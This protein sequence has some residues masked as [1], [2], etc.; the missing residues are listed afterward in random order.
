MAVKVIDTLKPKN[1]GTFPVVEAADVAIAANTRLP[2]ALA[3]KASTSDLSAATEDLQQQIDVESARIDEIIALPDGSTTAD[4]ELV[5]IR[6]GSDGTSY[7]SAGDAVRGQIGALK[8]DLTDVKTDF[9]DVFASK[10]YSVLGESAFTIDDVY[11]NNSGKFSEN[12]NFH[13]SDFISV[14][15]I[16]KIIFMHTSSQGTGFTIGFYSSDDFDG[17]IGGELL[18]DVHEKTEVDIPDNATYFLIC[19]RKGE[20]FLAV[21]NPDE[22]DE[23]DIAE[24]D[25]SITDLKQSVVRD[26]DGLTDYVEY[27]FDGIKNTASG[28]NVTIPYVLEYKSGSIRN[29]PISDP[30]ENSKAFYSAPKM[31]DGTEIRI[32]VKSGYKF[33]A[34]SHKSDGTYHGLITPTWQT[35][36]I[37][38]NPRSGYYWSIEIQK[39]D[40]SDISV[41]NGISIVTSIYKNLLITKSS[42]EMML[43]SVKYGSRSKYDIG[44]LR[45]SNNGIFK[46]VQLPSLGFMNGFSINLFTD[47]YTYKHYADLSAHKNAGGTIHI[48]RSQSELDSLTFQSGDTIK[49]ESGFYKIGTIDKSV[50]II[51]DNS[52]ITSVKIGEFVETATENVYRT[53]CSLSGSSVLVYD[54]SHLSDGII[55]QLEHVTSVDDLSTEGTYYAN[56]TNLYVHLYDNNVPTNRNVVASDPATNTIYV[57]PNEINTKVYLEG[58]VVIGGASNI[59]A[60]NTATYTSAMVIAKNCKF[61]YSDSSTGN[62]V[63]LKGVNGYFQNCE[64]AF[65]KMDGFNY[66]KNNDVSSCGLEIDCIG[67]DNGERG[68]PS[69]TSNNGTTV[70]DGGN[71]IRIGGMYYR[72]YGGN[73][74]DISAGTATYCYD[75][76]AFDSSAPDDTNGDFWTH[77]AGTMYLYGCRAI[78]GSEYNLRCNSGTI[79]QNKTEFDTEYGN[80]IGI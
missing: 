49:L 76:V 50:N 34:Y 71:A 64:A 56:G 38:V 77:Y 68:N 51:G 21:A 31:S 70:H 16:V 78:G 37:S 13:C 7:S 8:E 75:C 19:A 59:Y 45:H 2:E 3:A 40:A 62:A 15:G 9:S 60:A 6:V 5:D 73:V 58:I 66:H 52:V 67:H 28:E 44:G 22:V 39:E 46:R 29:T 80:V 11:L 25:Q 12:T 53:P 32:T 20:K 55:T 41:F 57:I 47:G 1:N 24:L 54:C 42:T 4:A 18:D 69:T 27:S 48:V 63:S 23:Y 65:A 72:N 35:G 61:L 14:S 36:T 43:N 10:G 79:Y 17:F 33:V 30:N 26:V 74:A